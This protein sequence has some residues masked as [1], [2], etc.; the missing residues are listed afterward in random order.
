[1]LGLSVQRRTTIWPTHGVGRHRLEESCAPGVAEIRA[2][3]SHPWLWWF[4]LS[5]HFDYPTNGRSITFSC[6]LASLISVGP[7]WRFP[8]RACNRELWLLHLDSGRSR[9]ECLD[10]GMA[11][12]GRYVDLS[13]AANS[14]H[15]TKLPIAVIQH[16]R[17]RAPDI[18]KR[19]R[20]YISPSV[21]CGTGT[22]Q[23]RGAWLGTIGDLR[24]SSCSTW[25]G[26]PGLWGWTTAARWRR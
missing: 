13:I 3:A 5:Y 22:T 18:R 16:R 23:G 7:L 1:M 8:R 25:S 24:Q 6:Q 10:A 21:P 11:G 20:W 14:R 12:G 26:T 9:R 17:C 2:A 4:W 15:S 19:G